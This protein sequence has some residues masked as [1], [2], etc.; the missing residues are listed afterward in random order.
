MI[1]INTILH[2]DN[3]CLKLNEF[4]LKDITFS[5]PKGQIMGLIG[6]NG[7]GKT[8]TIKTILNMV[9]I[10]KGKIEI[11]NKNIIKNELD[12]KQKIGIV[13]DS[14][15]FVE[16]WTTNEVEKAIGQ[17]YNKW[18]KN[19]F[20]LLL[21]KF[22]IKHKRIKEMSKGMQMKLMIACAIS[23]DAKLLILDEPTS[24]LDPV[25]RNELLEIINEYVID[26][27]HSVLF[28]TH[29]MEDLSQ[30]ANYITYINN[31]E[32]I[33]TGTKKKLLESFRMVEGEIKNLYPELMKSLIGIK[34]YGTKFRGL[35]R[36]ENINIFS[37]LIFE[38]PT[39]NDI[40][41]HTN[42]N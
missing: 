11:F 12:I 21:D 6:P 5:L 7:A 31:G 36:I 33:Y 23:Y 30:I 4:E 1:K 13:F 27:E 17:F 16:E 10:E 29:I 2:L 34:T 8:T 24:G 20:N 42:K 40:I 35:M 9:N 28:S 37:N 38:I 19:T 15:Y 14:N 18:N 3:V 32:I 26:K 39:M 41:I 25:S 22:N